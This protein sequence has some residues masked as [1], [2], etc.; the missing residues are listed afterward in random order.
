M[1]TAYFVANQKYEEAREL[2]YIQFPSRFVYHSDDKTW[3]PRKHGTAIGRLIYVHPTAG[4]K[5]YLR[6]LLNVVKDAFDFEDLCTV[7]GNGTAP[8]VNS[9]ERN[10][11]DGEQVIIGDKFMIPRTDH[12]HESISNAAYPDFV[13][14]Y[15]NRAYLTERAIL[16]PTNVSAHEI[17][18]Y[19]LPKVPSAEKEFL[20]SDSVAFESTPEEDWTNNYTQE[21]LN[22]LE[23]PGLPPHKLCLKVGAP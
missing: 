21:Y 11:D 2:T 14:K 19:L 23:F 15:L 17:N 1:L 3:T 8:T 4:D 20:S 6:I 5:Y 12:P 18:S 7:V 13:S 9:E 16:S 22:S 10:H